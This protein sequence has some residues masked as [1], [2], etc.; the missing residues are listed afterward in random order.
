MGAPPEGAVVGEE[1]GNRLVPDG[2]VGLR[3]ALRGC[4]AP[5]HDNAPSSPILGHTRR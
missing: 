3:H 2:N 5:R 4:V 1:V